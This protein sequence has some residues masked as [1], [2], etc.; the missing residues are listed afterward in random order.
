MLQVR[1]EPA[2]CLIVGVTDIIAEA[3]L[4]TV[5]GAYS[6]HSFIPEKSGLPV[7]ITVE[8]HG[9]KP[10]SG[11]VYKIENRPESSRMVLPVPEDVAKTLLF[12]LM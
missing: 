8:M 1:Q 4:L 7:L 10:L 2:T 5:D 11:P 12:W 6:G 9:A 3:R